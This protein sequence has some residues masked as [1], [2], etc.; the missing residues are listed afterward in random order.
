LTP[1]SPRPALVEADAARLPFAA[2]RFDAAL[3]V[4]VLHLIAGWRESLLEV[5]RVLRPGGVLLS[6]YDWRP[7]DSPG[8]LILEK[9][10]DIVRSRGLEGYQPG[11]RDFDDVKAALFEMGA[12]MREVSVGEWT[13]ARTLARHIETI[14][15][16]TW[17]STWIVPDDF[18]SNCLAELREWV[19]AEWGGLER[20]FTTPHRFIW[21]SFHWR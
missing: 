9:W 16:R 15:H 3:S 17:S 18:F 4:H 21:Q 19:V 7:P 6:G 12:M 1:D 8:A 2:G 5:R 20:E 11:A 13:T 14:E 10:R